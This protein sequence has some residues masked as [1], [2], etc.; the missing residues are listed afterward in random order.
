MAALSGGAVALVMV[1]LCC[2]SGCQPGSGSENPRHSTRSARSHPADGLEYETDPRT[3]G[4]WMVYAVGED[5]TGPTVRYVVTCW[6][7]NNPASFREVDVGAQAHHEYLH[8]ADTGSIPC[9]TPDP[10]VSR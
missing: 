4:R 3:I 9:P 7:D 10:T 8:L 1:T 6:R 2:I 5:Y